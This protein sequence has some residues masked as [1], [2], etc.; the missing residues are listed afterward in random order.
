MLHTPSSAL[1]IAAISN[2]SSVLGHSKYLYAYGSLAKSFPSKDIVLFMIYS[3]VTGVFLIS[4][5]LQKYSG[6]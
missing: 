5:L 1:R 2:S 6:V 3:V 4:L